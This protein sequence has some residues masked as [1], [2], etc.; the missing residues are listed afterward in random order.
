M[1]H[2]HKFVLAI[3]VAILCAFAFTT[4][5]ITP[6]D[7][8]RAAVAHQVFE[9]ARTQ[10]AADL[11]AGTITPQEATQRL[12]AAIKALGDELK[13]TAKDVEDRTKGID[14]SQLVGLGLSSILT[15]GATNLHRNAREAKVWGTPETPK[16][17]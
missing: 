16:G 13:A 17:A 14:W 12:E 8:Q 15:F 7:T 1:K 4:G 5:C 3:T 6:Q 10:T 9:E 2:A 11:A